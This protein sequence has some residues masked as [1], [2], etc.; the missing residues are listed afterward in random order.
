ML[1][2][3]GIVLVEFD[4][5][6]GPVIRKRNPQ[7]YSLPKMSFEEEFLMWVIR[8]S[9][10][11]V[12]KIEHQT[13]YAKAISLADPNFARKKRQFGLAIISKLTFELS[14]AELILNE[15]IK[16]CLKNSDNRSYFKMLNGLLLTIKNFKLPEN[17]LMQSIESTKEDV[18]E[19]VKN[20]TNFEKKLEEEQKQLPQ[21][22]ISNKLQIFNKVTI[23]DKR[24]IIE[25]VVGKAEG[26]DNY[27]QKQQ[28][29][30][31]SEK[32]DI[33][34]L[35]QNFAPTNLHIGLEIFLQILET[36][37]ELEDKIERIIIGIEFLDRLLYEDVDIEYYLPFIQYL[38]S[39]ENYTITEFKEEEFEKQLINLQETHGDWVNCLIGKNFDGGKL[40]Q[41]F[42]I[43]KIKR[44]GLELLID[45]LFI[46]LVSIH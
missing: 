15:L 27:K 45:L 4:S 30:V 24:G 12:R 2:N 16:S 33:N 7:D 44:E 29:N 18:L 46:K 1:D 35:L 22:I 20:N 6:K 37:K 23:Q 13:A 40:T 17:I 3:L 25:I 5:L 32:I 14:E 8:S 39:M 36:T 9:E 10:F 21:I 31:S 42:D 41:F 38:L 19:Q 43:T 34:V 11:S 26:F 28:K